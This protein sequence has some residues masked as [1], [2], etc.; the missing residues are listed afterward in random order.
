MNP[1]EALDLLKKLVKALGEQRRSAE[2]L[3]SYYDGQTGTL[4]YASSEWRAWFAEQY[5]GFTDNWCAPVVDATVERINVTGFRPF[6]A[7]RADQ[8]LQR[9][10]LSNG[11]DAESGLAFTEA[12]TTSRSFALVWPNDDDPSTPVLT[13]ESATEALVAY[14]PGSRRVRQAAVKVWK[15]EDTG[16]EHATLYTSSEVWKW[17]RRGKGGTSTWERREVDGEDWPLEHDFGAVPMVELPNRPKLRGAPMSEIANV[18]PMQDA[19]N[20]LWAHLFT[21]SD[22]AAMPQRLILGAQLPKVPIFDE[23][24]NKIG[25]KPIDLPEAAV[26]RI[27]NIEG[28][29]AKVDTWPAAKLDVFTDVIDIAVNHIANQTRTPAYYLVGGKTFANLSADAIKALD[30]GLVQKVGERKTYFGEALREVARLI[31]LA[32]GNQEKAAAMGAGRVL[33]TDHEVRSEA[34]R[35]DASLKYK[36]MGMPFAWIAARHIDD[37]DELAEVIRQYEQQQQAER[38]LGDFG[39]KPDPVND[40]D[41]DEEG[42]GAA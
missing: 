9:V 2:D 32:Q 11:A 12:A 22:F 29:T 8:D 13:F 35:A 39:P 42:E 37:P 36:Q 4:Q 20:L 24:G 17:Q 25:E 26:K 30:A 31:C 27:L 21:S 28:P 14:V 40:V 15:D 38:M 5:D 18:A 3:T 19:I 7:E 33:W 23:A 10:W 6:Q 41:A 34:Q 16:R 1:D